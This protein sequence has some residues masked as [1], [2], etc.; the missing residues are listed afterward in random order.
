GSDREHFEIGPAGA[1]RFVGRLHGRPVEGHP[2]GVAA[3]GHR[4]RIDQRNWLLLL[5]VAS[6]RRGADTALEFA[7]SFLPRR[8]GV[9]LWFCCQFVFFHPFHR[10]IGW[11]AIRAIARFSCPR[12]QGCRRWRR[13]SGCELLGE[14]GHVSWLFGSSQKKPR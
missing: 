4:Q 12:F 8:R 3:F 7:F 9:F 5:L 11:G 13:S 6:G 10:Q 14:L 2:V 1:V